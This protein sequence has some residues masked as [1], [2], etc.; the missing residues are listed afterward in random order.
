ML[1]K[2]LLAL[3]GSE[4]AE[5][6]LPWAKQVAARETAQVVLL[7]VVLP[8]GDRAA[9][10]RERQEAREYLQRMEKELNYAG[11]PGKILVR[12]GT[13]S[14]EIVDTAREEGCDLILMATRGGSK[15]RRWAVGGVTEQVLRLSPLPVLPVRSQLGMPRQGHVRRVIVPVDGSKLAESAVLWSIRLARLL[16]AKLIFLHV[17]PDG[18]GEQRRWNQK[19]FEALNKRFTRLCDSLQENGVKDHQLCGSKR[20]DPDDDARIRRLQA[21]GF[22]QRGRE[23]DS[24]G[25][26][27]GA[28][29]QESGLR[30]DSAPR[31]IPREAGTIPPLLSGFAGLLCGF[32][33]GGCWPFICS[34]HSKKGN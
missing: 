3:D 12:R 31:T 21:L 16:K 18:P 1:K 33:D 34:I 22:R 29:L 13:P 8:N 4:N 25:R 19:T 23:T 9:M 30:R 26:R 28:R 24:R 27:A 10:A 32:T 17:Y 6:A 7:R 2:I 5:K 11:I 14:R 15:V 20:P